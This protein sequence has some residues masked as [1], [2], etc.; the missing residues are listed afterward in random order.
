MDEDKDLEVSELSRSQVFDVASYMDA[1]YGA[2]RGIN[3]AFYDSQIE[4]KNLIDLNN[5]PKIPTYDTLRKTVANY[6]NGAEILQDYSEFMSVWDTIYSRIIDHKVNLLSFNRYEY[7]TNMVD[8]EI[9]MQSAE[10]KADKRRVKKFF[11][12]FNEK[13]EF[14]NVAKNVMKTDTYF[15]WLRD[16][17]GSFDENPIELEDSSLLVKRASGYALQMM[18]QDYCRISG[19]FVNERAK[20]YLWDFDLNYFNQAMVNVANFDPSLI[21]S[22]N[23]KKENGQLKSFINNNADLN[24]MNESFDGYVRTNVNKGAWLFKYNIDTFNAIPPLTSLLRA[25]FNNDTVEALQRD[26]DM[27]SAYAIIAGE[28]KTRKEGSDKNALLMDEKAVGALMK[29][30][31]KVANN[32]K[33]KQIPYPLEE[34]EMFQF[35]DSNTS[36][37]KNQFVSTAKQGTSASSLIYASEKMGEMEFK[38]SLTGDF[39]SI[40]NV[41]YPQFENFLN[42]YVNKKT[43]KYKFKFKVCGSN[44]PFL[45]KDELDNHIKL[46][47]KGM[48]VSLSRW[49]SLLGYNG[50]EFESLMEEAKYGNVQKLSFLLLNTN[51]IAQDGSGE[52]G[53]PTMDDNEISDAGATSRQY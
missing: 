19:S 47:D 18:P 34:L 20:G 45:R 51:T 35:T 6:K 36:M 44:I 33:I 52:V 8:P 25:S 27:I 10:Y 32:E 42:F 28:M 12:R 5:N 41:L 16:S 30:A 11:E 31:R 2:T 7:C 21:E 9:E 39:Y 4:N 50:D 49:G 15:T 1:L 37:A 26:K 40:A 24:K 43:K 38:S 17:S 46:S 48:Q 22:F 23:K 3:Y 29:M 13:Q 14:L 53:N